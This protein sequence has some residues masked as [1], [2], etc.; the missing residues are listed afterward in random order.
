MEYAFTIAN[1]VK[2]KS[3]F[4]NGMK[5][6][7]RSITEEH[8]QKESSDH[9]NLLPYSSSRG[10]WTRMGTS[11]NYFR[12]WGR[13]ETSTARRLTA[14]LTKSK[15]SK[16]YFS[17]SF[18]IIFPHENDSCYISYCYPYTYTDLHR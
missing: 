14:A 8:S 12:T 17:A 1:L 18:K 7:V 9:S 4:K 2:R 5:V 10:K 3:H 13:F 6:L 16:A 15:V 11:P